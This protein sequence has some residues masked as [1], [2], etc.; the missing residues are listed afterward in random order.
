MIWLETG[1]PVVAPPNRKGFGS[2]LID[3]TVNF[4]LGGTAELTFAPG[5]LEARFVVPSEHHY[6]VS[7]SNPRVAE[8]AAIGQP[9]AGLVVMLVEDQGLIALDT[10][11]VLRSLGAAEVR[12]LPNVMLAIQSLAEEEPQCAVLDLNLGN[13]TSEEIALDLTKRGIPFV[14]ATGYRDSVAIPHRFS[15]V[16][17]VRKPITA[18]ALASELSIAL[19]R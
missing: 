10:E 14:F 19:A 15:S 7:A 9:L 8:P 11:D 17:V 3:K 1:G 13:E 2:T 18:R 5:G 6:E 12:T 4:D 16:P